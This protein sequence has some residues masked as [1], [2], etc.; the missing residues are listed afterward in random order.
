MSTIKFKEEYLD[1]NLSGC[2]VDKDKKFALIHIFKNA[3]IS[4]RN[5]LGMRGRYLEWSEA[6]NIEGLKTICVIRNP[7]D[8]FI[9]A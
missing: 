2:F 3:S 8:R 6:K 1:Y 9:S 5:A 7:L 4:I